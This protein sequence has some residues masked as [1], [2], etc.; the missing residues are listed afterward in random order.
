MVIYTKQRTRQL[1]CFVSDDE[2]KIIQQQAKL[3]NRSVSNFV[4]SNLKK[5]ILP[6]ELSENEN[7]RIKNQ[8][9]GD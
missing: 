4:Y 8:F 9:G 5:V 6:N 3:E 7:L 1:T 2:M